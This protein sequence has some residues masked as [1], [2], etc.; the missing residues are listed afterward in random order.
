M[1]ILNE[2]LAEKRKRAD[3]DDLKKNQFEKSM[4]TKLNAFFAVVARDF[5]DIYSSTG[6]IQNF[7]IYTDDM[8]SLLKTSYRQS[9]R[10]FQDNLKRELVKNAEEQ[11]G[12]VSEELANTLVEERNAIDINLKN[13]LLSVILIRTGQQATEILGT[14]EKVI[15]KNVLNTLIDAA[16]EGEALTNEEV[17][18]RATPKIRKE[19]LNRS[20]N[21]AQTE[22]QWASEGAKQAEGEMFEDQLLREGVTDP[23]GQ[24]PFLE[25]T[26]ITMGDKSVRESHRVANGQKRRIKEPYLVQGQ[27]LMRPGD[28][29]L[30]ATLDNVIRCRCVSVI[31]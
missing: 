24:T 3:A 10:W 2:T 18:R 8:T 1:A 20:S 17:A 29:S 15:A 26:W 5:E 6:Q 14:T 12:T 11:E 25:K 4:I 19:N 7:N 28:T 30:G 31:G 23:D 21:I 27:L 16:V 22:I 9:S 13:T